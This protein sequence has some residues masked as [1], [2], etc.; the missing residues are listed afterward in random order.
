M[1]ACLSQ[2][3]SAGLKDVI[4]IS[5]SKGL[6]DLIIRNKSVIAL[7]RILHD[8]SVLS[9]SFNSISFVF[10]SRVCNEAADRLAKSTLFSNSNN[11]SEIDVL[12]SV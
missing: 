5:D 4:C 2:A 6:I 7:R 1:K 3:A 8:I 10:V 11:D 9:H 12:V